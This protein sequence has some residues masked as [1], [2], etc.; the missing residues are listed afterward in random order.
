MKIILTVLMLKILSTSALGFES[1]CTPQGYD[2]YS[3]TISIALTNFLSDA[4][5]LMINEKSGRLSISSINE[6]MIE[7]TEL[8]YKSRVLINSSYENIS[9]GF[10]K[11]IRHTEYI[12][13]SQPGCKDFDIVSIN[14]GALIEIGLPN[15]DLSNFIKVA[16]E[17]YLKNENIIPRNNHSGDHSLKINAPKACANKDQFNVN[18][19]R[20]NHLGS[21]ITYKT[22][23]YLID[24]PSLSLLKK[25]TRPG[26]TLMDLC[27][28]LY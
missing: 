25:E 13:E 1:T 10:G 7:R 12:L 5:N 14:D 24:G 27:E 22:S 6:E 9:E 23:T 8:G 2:T 19:V 17:D 20:S 16:V 26:R 28:K 3:K 15:K 4:N 18:I 21:G 11:K